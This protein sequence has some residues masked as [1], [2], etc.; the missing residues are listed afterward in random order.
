MKEERFLEELLSE[1]Q[2]TVLLICHDRAFLNN[3][4]ASTLVFGKNGEIR[5]IVGGYDEWLDEK[6]VPLK[7][8]IKQIQN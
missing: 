5:E 8:R 6:G 1:F 4:V 3:V 7:E 2:G